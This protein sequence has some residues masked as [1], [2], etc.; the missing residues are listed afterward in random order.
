ML[1][2]FNSCFLPEYCALKLNVHTK[3]SCTANAAR[4]TTLQTILYFFQENDSGHRYFCC[5]D[6]IAEPNLCLCHLDFESH[7]CYWYRIM[8]I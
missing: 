8:A 5:Y 4:C 3:I 7:V 6:W 1:E 2:T